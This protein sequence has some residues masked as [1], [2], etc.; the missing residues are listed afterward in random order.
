MYHHTQETKYRDYKGGNM[1]DIYS[2]IDMRI[3]PGTQLRVIFGSEFLVQE[4][5]FGGSEWTTVDRAD[6]YT[7]AFAKF[8]SH[9][10]MK[11]SEGNI[12]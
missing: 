2:L 9:L 4:F 1:E 6:N 7:S 10:L 8:I 3:S 11:L 12:G 5:K